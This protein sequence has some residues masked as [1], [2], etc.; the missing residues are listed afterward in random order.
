[1]THGE[2]VDCFHRLSSSERLSVFVGIVCI[3]GAF[4]RWKWLVDPPLSWSPFYS[5]A[6]IKKKM[7]IRFLLY[8][9]YFLGIVF[10]FFGVYREAVRCYQLSI[11]PPHWVRPSN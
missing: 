3:L 8:F 11:P 6:A 4:L 1:M 9:T 5:Q 7:G 2:L 10:L